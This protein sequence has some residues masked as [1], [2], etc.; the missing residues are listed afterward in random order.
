M[1]R[2]AFIS[3]A[4]PA[5]LGEHVPFDERGA[6]TCSA[7]EFDYETSADPLALHRQHLAVYLHATG[8]LLPDCNEDVGP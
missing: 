4:P 2:T 7:T 5:R 3:A 6:C 1:T 8:G